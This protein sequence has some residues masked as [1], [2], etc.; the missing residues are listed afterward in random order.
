LNHDPPDLCL[1]SNKEYRCE[2]LAPA[3]DCCFIVTLGCSVM[4]VTVLV[5]NIYFSRC[6]ASDMKSDEALVHLTCVA[7]ERYF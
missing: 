1:L 6:V 2:P 4:A 5:G 3:L 7:T